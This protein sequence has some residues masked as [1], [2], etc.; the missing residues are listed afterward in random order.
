[1]NHDSAWLAVL[2]AILLPALGHVYHFILA[3]NV[4]SGLGFRE[5][6]LGRI[7]LV[8]L[9]VLISSAGFLLWKHLSDPWWTWTWPLKAYA[10]LCVA[11][12]A[13]IWPL[14]SLNLKTRKRPAG[15]SG[16]TQLLDLG[17]ECGTETLIG[18]GRGAWQL[19]LPGNQSLSLC[20]REYEAVL[21]G[22]PRELDGLSIVQLTDLHFSPVYD[23]SFFDRV[24]DACRAWPADLV[25][26]T[27]DL[28]DS[29]QAL[30]WIEPVLGPLERGWGSSRSWA[31]TTPST[32]RRRSSRRWRQPGTSLWKGAGLSWTRTE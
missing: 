20:R 10:L 24:V 22:L 7:R 11:S 32:I 5:R 27:G 8:L 17:K 23:R 1:M 19:R 21:S 4:T 31:T 15:V 18:R 28:I 25:L 29:D 2:G 3:V 14:C 13:I 9:A 26:I 30:S 6:A 12:G 16:R